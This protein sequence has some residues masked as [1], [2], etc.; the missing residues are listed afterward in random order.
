MILAHTNAVLSL[1]RADATL[2]GIVFQGVVTNRPA[3]YVTVYTNNGPR[4]VSRLTG[5]QSAVTFTYIVHSVGQTPEQAQWV[6]EKVYLQLVD[7][8]P[9]V[10][11]RVVSPIRSVSSLSVQIDRDIDPPL[12]YCVD[13]FDLHTEPAA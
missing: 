12:W 10:P 8:V 7:A 2:A 9:N 13:E 1:L 6:A 5:P 4:E 11:G 3:R